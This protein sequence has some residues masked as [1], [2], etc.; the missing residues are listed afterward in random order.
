MLDPERIHLEAFD[1][2][3]RLSRVRDYVEKNF[4]ESLPLARVAEIAGMGP[5]SFSTF[6][7][8]KVGVS[9]TRWLANYRVEKAKRILST[10]DTPISHIAY[11]VG[12]HDIRT[13]Q[14]AFKTYSGMTA[15]S[16][17]QGARP[18]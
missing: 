5:N 8:R 18:S 10:H 4:R 9:F 1:Y 3:D 11:E 15:R 17:K 14:R 6:F 13:F 12:F 7:R 16:F 2:Y